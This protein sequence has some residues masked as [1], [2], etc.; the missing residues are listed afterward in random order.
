MKNIKYLFAYTIPISAI[1]GIYFKD[2]WSFTTPV[3]AFVLVPV[4]ELLAYQNTKNLD[5]EERNKKSN[6]IWFDIL[7]YLNL[8]IVISILVYSIYTFNTYALTSIEIIGLILTTGIVLGSSGI[9]VAHELGH[10]STV[11][12]KIIAKILLLPSFYMHFYVEHNF[13]HHLKAATAEDPATAQYNQSLYEF[14]VSSV[15]GQYLSAW[16]IQK[17]LLVTNGTGFISIKNDMLWYILAQLGY[18]AT[19]GF[20]FG[21]TGVLYAIAVGVVGFL[22]LETINYIEHYGLRRNKKESGRYERVTEVHSWNSNHIIGRILLYELTR[23]SDH[24]YKSTKKYQLL[25]Y[26]DISPQL[27]YGYPTSMVI[28]LIPP[29]WFKIMNKRVPQHMKENLIEYKVTLQ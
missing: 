10:R 28:A 16:R 15:I 29:L 7:L 8:P 21:I 3:F 20:F 6:L 4:I 24:H 26:H 12:E 19:V 18:L 9:N 2:I 13:G 27:P 5:A 17:K 22:L 14:W 23:H 11:A 1:L 25:D